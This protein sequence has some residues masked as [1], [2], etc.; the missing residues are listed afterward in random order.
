LRGR[1]PGVGVF[2]PLAGKLR[3]G[4]MRGVDTISDY[5]RLAG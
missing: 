2:V 1:C 5:R 4:P 3:R